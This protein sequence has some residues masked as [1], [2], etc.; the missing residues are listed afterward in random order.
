MT[1]RLEMLVL[2]CDHERK[3]NQQLINTE[4]IVGFI[5]IY[6][7]VSS[8]NL[9]SHKRRERKRERENNDEFENR[10]Q[11][12]F[13]C[14]IREESSIWWSKNLLWTNSD[15]LFAQ[16]RILYFPFQTWL[17]LFIDAIFFR[18]SLSYFCAISFVVLVG[19]RLFF[20]E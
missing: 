7:S 15:P 17:T 18:H 20:G 8:T 4:M 2:S 14:T 6:W 10:Y 19:E 1:I 11:N 16:D 3:S 5:R 12:K 9:V 13:D